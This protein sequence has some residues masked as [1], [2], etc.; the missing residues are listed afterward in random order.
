MDTIA[1]V[2]VDTPL[3]VSYMKIDGD[4]NLLQKAAIESTTLFN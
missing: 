3:G 4:L 1:V 2:D